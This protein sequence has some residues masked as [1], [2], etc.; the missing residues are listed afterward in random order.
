MVITNNNNNNSDGVNR[1]LC[2]VNVNVKSFYKIQIM[3]VSL[4]FYFSQKNKSIYLLYIPMFIYILYT[5]TNDMSLYD[6][7]SCCKQP[8]KMGFWHNKTYE[9]NQNKKTIPKQCKINSRLCI[10]GVKRAAHNCKWQQNA[11]IKKY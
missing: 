4:P 9:K 10:D 6:V 2:K 7:S 5:A 8:K 1:N 3:S 11:R